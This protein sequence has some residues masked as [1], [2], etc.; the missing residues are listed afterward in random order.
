[1]KC[2]IVAA[3]ICGMLFAPAVASAAPSAPGG[4]GG[5]RGTYCVKISTSPW[6]WGTWRC[7]Y[8]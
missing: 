4:G 8:R 7:Y 3:V 1:M 5:A 2:L 6:P